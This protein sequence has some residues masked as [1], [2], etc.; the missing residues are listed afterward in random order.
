[1]VP[2]VIYVPTKSPTRAPTDSASARWRDRDDSKRRPSLPERSASIKQRN[3]L[4]KMV[5]PPQRPRR[6]GSLV[7]H[8]QVE[9][10]KLA[11]VAW[12]A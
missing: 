7:H 12:A 2:L 8:H 5:A 6:R 4:K 1:M 11:V 10:E 9:A 3:N